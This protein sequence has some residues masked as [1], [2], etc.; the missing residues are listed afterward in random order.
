MTDSHLL[1]SRSSLRALLSLGASLLSII[2]C[3]IAHA[4]DPGIYQ[5]AGAPADPKVAARWNRYHDFAEATALLKQLAETHPKH[6]RLES[7][8]KSYG[9][10]QMWLMTIGN[11]AAE[12]LAARPAFWIDG[13]I[14]ANEIQATEVVLYTAWYLLEMNGRNPYVTRLLD[15]RTFYLMPMMSPDSRDRHMHSAATTHSPR[16]GARPVDDDRDGLVDEDHPDDLDGDGSI[17]QMRIPDRNGRYKPHPDHPELLILAKPDERGSYTI[18]DSEGFDN[19]S[20]G[21]VDEDGDGS[22][23]PNRNWPWNWQ[24]EYVQGGAHQYPLSVLED[25]MVARFFADHPQIG[26]GQSYHNAGG[27]ILRG[28]GVKADPYDSADTALLKKIAARGEQMLP[29]Y[30]SME[31][32]GELYETYGLEIDWLY[33]GCGALAYTNELFT[34]YSYFHNQEKDGGFF[35]TPEQSRQFD[36]RLLFGDGVVKWHEVNHPQFGKIEVGGLKKNWVRQPPSFMI[37]EECHRNMAFSLYHAEQL[38]QVKIDAVK[39]EPFAGK[40]RQV[41]ATIANERMIPTRIAVNVKNRLTPPDRVSLRGE[42]I[43]VIA[44]FTSEDLLWE[45]PVAQKRNPA[46]LELESIPGMSAR[47]TRW[48]IEGEGPITVEVVSTKGGRASKTVE[49]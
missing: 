26:G 40:V 17:T 9:G 15:T 23:D 46:V 31:V 38:P 14:H 22:Y 12:E 13:G 41:T 27:M 16:T 21:R 36:E 39:I 25:R 43:R 8:G 44:G 30:K 2:A 32:A 24:P 42:N 20:D 37:E 7:L 4:A 34:A 29:G 3:A 33:H 35:G 48:L 11:G 1:L 47:Y 45:H 28:P 49:K 6:C 18:I 10:R 5:P 19:D